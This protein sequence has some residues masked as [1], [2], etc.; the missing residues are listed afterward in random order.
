MNPVSFSL[1]KPG[2][3]STPPASMQYNYFG[4]ILPN[5]TSSKVVFMGYSSVFNMSTYESSTEM[6]HTITDDNY[7]SFEFLSE[8]SIFN[9]TYQ[10]LYFGYDNPNISAIG[11]SNPATGGTTLYN[12]FSD[13]P[14]Y[15]E[16]ITSTNDYVTWSTP[17]KFATP[18][19]T[20][21]YTYSATPPTS[22]QSVTGYETAN[23]VA[24]GS[25]IITNQYALVIP[26]VQASKN[27]WMQEYDPQT[28]T[29]SYTKVELLGGNSYS[30]AMPPIY[31]TL[32]GI[33][34]SYVR[35]SYTTALSVSINVNSKP[36][37][38]DMTINN[39]PTYGGNYL[40][41]ENNVYPG[42][43]AVLS[44]ILFEKPGSAINFSLTDAG[45]GLTHPTYGNNFQMY[46]YVPAPAGVGS[47]P[48]YFM[49][50]VQSGSAVVFP[51]QSPIQ[52]PGAGFTSNIVNQDVQ[53][54]LTGELQG[55]IMG[56]YDANMIQQYKMEGVTYTRLP[57]V[58]ITI[59]T[60]YA[61]IKSIIWKDS[62]DGYTGTY[63]TISSS[64]TSYSRNFQPQAS[65]MGNVVWSSASKGLSNVNE[66][67]LMY[68]TTYAFPNNVYDSSVGGGQESIGM[69]FSP[70][71]KGDI[72]VI[73]QP[74]G[75]AV[76]NDGY[77]FRPTRGFSNSNN[78]RALDGSVM[79]CDSNLTNV[80]FLKHPSVT[81]QVKPPF[82][83]TSMG[84]M[85][86]Q[87]EIKPN[88]SYFTNS[89]IPESEAYIATVY[90]YAFNGGRGV[91]STGVGNNLYV[92]ILKIYGSYNSTDATL[93]EYKYKFEVW[94]L[95]IGANV[96]VDKTD[97]VWTKMLESSEFTSNIMVGFG[98]SSSAGGAT[99]SFDAKIGAEQPA[100]EMLVTFN[101]TSFDQMT[102]Q[103]TVIVNETK[104][105]TLT[106][107]KTAVE[108]VSPTWTTHMQYDELN[109]R[110][111]SFIN[112]TSQTS[113]S[114]ATIPNVPSQEGRYI[115]LL[116]TGQK[117][118][119][120]TQ[121]VTW[122]TASTHLD[123][124]LQ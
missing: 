38:A 46:C 102:G 26:L 106:N 54:D 88:T 100:T 18:N 80:T 62:G 75:G 114:Y 24:V 78:R 83:Y 10:R 48:I 45:A 17:A 63:P 50:L 31:K 118:T 25:A 22:F 103:Q 2:A 84:G 64:N 14:S 98:F 107:E 112:I 35:S 43:N 53:L 113:S 55:W 82:V 1:F 105:F 16:G 19:F 120:G 40:D 12:G 121:T 92:P 94:H 27:Y 66:Q 57:K 23:A 51:G 89:P 67:F 59:D 9:D 72:L 73:A 115:L 69:M 30:A 61:M 52:L 58:T 39:I 97:V 56:T 5:L 11:T 42:R 77:G 28:Q 44:E 21:V 96:F 76:Y 109:D 20:T 104:A 37:P 7:S 4:N 87:Q 111:A 91:Q 36:F 95:E 124:F 32:D 13:E 71:N 29:Q 65:G 6:R 116:G 93:S 117:M 8:P 33:N 60:S 123:P 101:I 81:H 41:K 34:Y 79:I 74:T 47:L 122:L 110:Y 86:G 70:N 85:G 99:M 108:V 119:T 15:L 3:V 49:L 68:S 90:S